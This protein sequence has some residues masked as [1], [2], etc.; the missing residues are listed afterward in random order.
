MPWPRSDEDVAREDEVTIPVQV[1]GKLRARIV[2]PA[3]SDEALLRER[4]LSEPDVS[5]HIGDKEPKRVIIVPG[6]LINIV[7]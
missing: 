3:G 7:V 4:A 6:R 2:V 5:T 1:N